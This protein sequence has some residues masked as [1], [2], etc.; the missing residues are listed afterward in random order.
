M[1]SYNSIL[2]L[3]PVKKIQYARSFMNR[4]VFLLIAVA[5]IAIL[6]ACREN[7]QNPKCCTGDP[8]KSNEMT[9]TDPVQDSLRIDSL[10]DTLW[11]LECAVAEKPSDKNRAK[12]LLAKSLDSVSGCFYIVGKGLTNP[13]LPEKARP[14]AQKTSAQY[15]AEK[16]VLYLKTLYSG[17]KISYGAQISGEVLYNKGLR[18]RAADDSLFVLVMIPVGSVVVK[19]VKL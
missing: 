3:F 8:V 18:T 13:D 4:P 19:D 5:T 7:G 9:V 16:W 17:E 6:G 1:A 14:L 2:R 12:K 15:S 11:Q 10:F